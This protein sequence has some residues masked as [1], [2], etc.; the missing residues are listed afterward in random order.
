MEGPFDSFE[1]LSPQ[2][3][4]MKINEVQSFGRKEKEIISKNSEIED[5]P[6]SVSQIL[7]S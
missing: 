4:F 1:I 5:L 3:E 2:I 7:F 6:P